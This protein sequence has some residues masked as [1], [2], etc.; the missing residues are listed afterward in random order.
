M[1]QL[2][3]IVLTFF[4]SLFSSAGSTAPGCPYPDV[5]IKII[6]P[7]MKDIFT[8]GKGELVCEATVLKQSLTKIWWEDES[9]NVLVTNNFKNGES[10]KTLKLDITFDEWSQG[11]TRNCFIEHSEWLQPRK[12][13]Y[14]RYTGMSVSIFLL[15]QCRCSCLTIV[16]HFQEDTFCNRQCFCCLR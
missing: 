4:P 10:V 12:E 3:W 6:E 11:I 5:L 14:H 15:H 16:S 13:S 8:N 7:T 9:G 1:T 2:F